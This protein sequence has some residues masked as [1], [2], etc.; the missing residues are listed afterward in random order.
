[1]STSE[2]QISMA[3]DTGEV[4]RIQYHGG[5]QPGAIR[6]I[7][8]KSLKNGKVR[9]YCYSSESTKSFL[10]N[11]IEVVS[12]EHEGKEPEWKPVTDKPPSYQ[13][14]QDFVDKEQ[15]LLGNQ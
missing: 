13:S 3:I 1:M 10:L 9:A 5:S 4:L 15:D 2:E 14:L 7:A 11:K 8:P 12:N 6:E